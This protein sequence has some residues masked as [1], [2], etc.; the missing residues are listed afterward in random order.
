MPSW[1]LLTNKF[2]LVIIPSVF[3]TLSIH[4]REPIFKD[5]ICRNIFSPRLF[6]YLMGMFALLCSESLSACDQSCV[7]KFSSIKNSNKAEDLKGMTIFQFKVVLVCIL[8]VI[9]IFLHFLGKT[10]KKRRKQKRRESGECEVLFLKLPTVTDWLWYHR[11]LTSSECLCHRFMIN[12]TSLLKKRLFESIKWRIKLAYHRSHISLVS[13]QT[14]W[15]KLFINIL[16]ND[17]QFIVEPKHSKEMINIHPHL[18]V[19]ECRISQ[20]T[21]CGIILNS[22]AGQ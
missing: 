20:P 22:F 5:L 12:V 10:T 3:Q 7:V 13:I 15:K 19:E 8:K 9:V 17:E 6:H 16:W 1:Y 14:C 21:S 4:S 2:S 18:Y 11:F